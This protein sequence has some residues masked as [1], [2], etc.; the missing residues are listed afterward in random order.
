MSNNPYPML[1]RICNPGLIHYFLYDLRIKTSHDTD[2]KSAPARENILLLRPFRIFGSGP[3]HT[4][5][6][7]K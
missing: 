2:C 1:V 6:N 5:N 3:L 4:P 7:G